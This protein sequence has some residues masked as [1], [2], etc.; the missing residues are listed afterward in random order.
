MGRGLGELG[1][2]LQIEGFCHLKQLTGE[3]WA[4]VVQRE[5]VVGSKKR[6]SREEKMPAGPSIPSFFTV[7]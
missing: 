6:S 3:C 7:D 2:P 1:D 5:V 4:W